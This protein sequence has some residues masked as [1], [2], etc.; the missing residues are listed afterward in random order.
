LSL[1]E[2][3][4]I[5]IRIKECVRKCEETK[6]TEEK[7]DKMSIKCIRLTEPKNNNTT[8]VISKCVDIKY[9]EGMGR[10]LFVSKDIKPGKYG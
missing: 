4:I 8:E 10:G 7:I 6:E 2:K 5:Q 1:A 9:S 3:E